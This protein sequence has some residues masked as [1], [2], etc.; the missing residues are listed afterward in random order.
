VLPLLVHEVQVWPAAGAE[1]IRRACLHEGDLMIDSPDS[2]SGRDSLVRALV[3]RALTQGSLRARQLLASEIIDRL[4]RGPVST[5]GA[6]RDVRRFAEVRLK[7][8]N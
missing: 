1:V 3:R 8:G 4:D 7:E 6:V 5:V 2:D